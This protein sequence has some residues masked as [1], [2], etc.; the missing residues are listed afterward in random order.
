MRRGTATAAG[1]GREYRLIRHNPNKAGNRWHSHPNSTA[2]NQNERKVCSST[3][4]V[5]VMHNS[6]RLHLINASLIMILFDTIFASITTISF[7]KIA[8]T[9]Y[10]FSR[11]VLYVDTGSAECGTTNPGLLCAN[12]CAL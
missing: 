6:L 5:A 9:S 3:R 8:G 7:R 1:S 12:A 4:I 2:R 11:A 10:L